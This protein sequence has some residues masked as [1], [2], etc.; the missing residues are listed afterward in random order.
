MNEIVLIL[1]R[2]NRKKNQNNTLDEFFFAFSFAIFV[3]N[4]IKI[5]FS[6]SVP[7]EIV[8]SLI[9]NNMMNAI[10]LKKFEDGTNFL[11]ESIQI[12]DDVKKARVLLFKTSSISLWYYSYGLLKCSYWCLLMDYKCC[13]SCLFIVYDFPEWQQKVW[14]NE[15][16]PLN[17]YINTPWMTRIDERLLNTCG[18]QT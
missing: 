16:A 5:T 13:I 4:L 9:N 2:K 1:G 10:E 12:I 17:T 14:V 7:F 8:A 6:T 18:M 15:I 3:S 11:K